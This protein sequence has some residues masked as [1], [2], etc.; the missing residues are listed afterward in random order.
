[1]SRRS[2]RFFHFQDNARKENR[3]GAY[4][5]SST[6]VYL[7]TPYAA[8]SAW[9]HGPHWLS[10]AGCTAGGLVSL[11]VCN[12]LQGPYLLVPYSSAN[13]TCGGACDAAAA[14]R[15]DAASAS[16]PSGGARVAIAGWVFSRGGSRARSLFIV[17]QSSCPARCEMSLQN[18]LCFFEFFTAGGRS[19]LVLLMMR[20]TSALFVAWRQS[21][22][23]QAGSDTRIE[24]G[25]P[26]T[27]NIS[28][29]LLHR[30]H[31]PEALSY[32]S[33]GP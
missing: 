18:N 5:L 15:M 10:S 17:C 33:A 1:M 4:R 20:W 13:T 27:C 23:T 12:W 31:P 25:K 26:P 32:T 29:T 9:L 8:S 14:A 24:R 3:H 30:A 11:R 22:G 28:H 7:H 21:R 19:L 2:K 6:G 16:V